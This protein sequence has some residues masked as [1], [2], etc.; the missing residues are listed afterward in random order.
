MYYYEILPKDSSY[1]SEKLLTYESDELI[2]KYSLVAIRLK[3]K[4]IIGLVIKN[5]TKPR[6][7]TSPVISNLSNYIGQLPDE[8]VKLLNWIH[9]YYPGPAGLILTQFIPQKIIDI[10]E[11]Y[12]V[13]NTTYAYNSAQLPSLSK[14]QVSVLESITGPATYVLHGDTGT[15]KTRVYIELAKR[16]IEKKKTTLI[17]I[18]EISLTPQ[19]TKIFEENFGNRVIIINSKLS[20]SKKLQN[21]LRIAHDD[22]GLIVIGPRSALF[23]P[24]RSLGLVVVDEFHEDAYKQEQSPHYHAN[25]VASMLAKI[26]KSVLIFGSATPPIADYY[27]AK[28]QKTP[29]LRMLS[30]PITKNTGQIFKEIVDIKDHSEFT[31][32][33]LISNKLI[34]LIEAA[35]KEKEQSLLFLNRR[36]TARIVFC[37]NCGW[38]SVCPN[39][40]LPLIFHADKFIAI[41]HSCG[42]TKK[43]PMSCPDCNEEKIIYR[44]FGTKALIDE[45]K[46][47][48]PNARIQRFDNDNSSSESFE[49]NYDSVV[50]GEVDILIGTQT[51]SRGL[52]LPNLSVV[53]IMVAESSLSFPDFTASEKTY[54]QINQILGRIGRG[55]KKGNAIIQTYSPDNK[56]IVDSINLN[57]EDYFS[58]EIEERKKFLYPPFVQIVKLTCSKAT[59]KDAEKASKLLFKRLENLKL[60]ITLLGPAPS[61]YSKKAGKFQYQIIVKSKLRS[62]LIKAINNLPSGWDYDLDPLNLL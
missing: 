54:Q 46:R 50:S 39:C 59:V 55:H 37:D 21:W 36:G 29:I 1:F 20:P 16:S 52:D 12:S 61:F 6:F 13:D 18:P 28:E 24:F 4:S 7:K 41:C 47:L 62:N 31:K 35:L 38:Q 27:L 30:N 25:R 40:D 57:Y 5:T 53:G 22:Q 45:A 3:S 15:G 43:P 42:L 26:H 51:L 19:F 23:S 34:N 48:F 8:S 58:G 2:Q 44:G 11:K 56:T 49:H 14:E 60:D 9:L 32:S 10:G 17:M 33:K